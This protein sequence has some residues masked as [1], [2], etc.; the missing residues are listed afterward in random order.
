M[1]FFDKLFKKKQKTVGNPEDKYVTII[2]DRS[3]RVEHPSRKPEEILWEDIREIRLVNTDEGPFLPDI[4]LMLIGETNGCSIPHG[5][6]GYND[7][8]EIV[9]KY[10]N[11]NFENVIKSMSSANNEQF[12]LWT[13]K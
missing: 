2:T 8:Y 6:K 7:V 12:L 1:I 10:E 11:F 3:V 9:S 4:W 13:K 5:S